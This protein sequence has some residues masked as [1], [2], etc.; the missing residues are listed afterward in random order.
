VT[1]DLRSYNLSCRFSKP[2]SQSHFR[3]I[4]HTRSGAK[5]RRM[6]ALSAAVSV[7]RAENDMHLRQIADDTA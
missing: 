6:C 5:R 3:V 1:R 4:E 7:A 2:L